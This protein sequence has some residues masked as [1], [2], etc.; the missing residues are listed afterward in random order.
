MPAALLDRFDLVAFDPPGVD[1]TAPITCL[2]PGQLYQY[3]HVNPAPTTPAGFNTLVDSDRQFAQGCEAKSGSELPYVSTIDA[4]MDMDTIRQ[5]LGDA[6]LSFIGFSYG[7]FLGATYAG[8]FP[9]R[10]RAMV[11]DGPLDPVLPVI[12][13]LDQQAA[14]LDKQL[15]LFTARCQASPSC[16]W[17]PGPDPDA[18][19]GTLVSKVTARPLPARGTS[20][21]VGPSELLFGTAAA[22]YSTDSWA[23]LEEALAQAS[24]GDGTDLMHLFDSYTGRNSKG[25]YSNLFEANAA[26]NCLDAPAPTLAQIQAGA[27]AAESQAPVF[28]LQNLDSGATCSV[29]PIPATG[30]PGPITAAGSPPILVVGSTGDP[31]TPYSW[32]QALASELEQGVL[33]TRVGDGHTAYGASSCIR[34]YVDAYLIALTPPPGGV[35]CSSG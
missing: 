2:D 35:R 21:T 4:A 11:L 18:A 34:T 26:I 5:A 28:G 33:L 15:L 7:T 27:A 8:L 25:G 23:F 3:F 30:K 12:T 32:A 13:E 17:K 19:F 22:L 6:K 24:S 20:R 31:I 1:R 14:A 16:P 10:V 9:D 29:W